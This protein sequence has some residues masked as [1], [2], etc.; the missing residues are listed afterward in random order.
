MLRST[1]ESVKRENLVRSAGRNDQRHQTGDPEQG[2]A[3]TSDLS[4]HEF[5][6]E[7]N[8]EQKNPPGVCARESE[9]LVWS[10]RRNDD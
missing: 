7:S 8:D 6:L 3:N 2:R 10:A 9:D 1:E 4:T 5:L